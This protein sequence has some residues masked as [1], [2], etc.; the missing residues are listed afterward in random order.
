MYESETFGFSI[1]RPLGEV[2]E[3]LLEPTNFPKWAFGDGAAPMRRIGKRDWAVETSVGPRIIRFAERNAHGVLDHEIL[4]FE[5]D[6][7]HPTGFW[8]VAN[9]PGTEVVY[10]NFRREGMSSEEWASLKTWVATDLLALQSLLESHGRVEGLFP[11][12]AIGISIRQPL[13]QVYGFLAE[14]LNFPRWAFA[15][16]TQMEPLPGGEFAVETSVGPRIMKFA[17][18]NAFGILTYT[19]RLKEGGAPLPIPMRVFPNGEGTELSYV[20]YQRPHTTETEWRSVMEWVTADLLALK[21]ML[22]GP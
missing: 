21:S 6:A 12:R 2:Y 4:R 5:G 11:A 18:R 3:F 17:E 1:A 14:P 22:E 16:E 19:S 9:G 7:P 8:V 20:F 10:T 15:H 13:R